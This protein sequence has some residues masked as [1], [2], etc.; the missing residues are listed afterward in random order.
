MTQTKTTKNHYVVFLS[1][2]TFVSES[3]EKEVTKWHPPLAVGK[4]E[5]IVERYGAK[6]YAFYFV[7]YLVHPP[8]D[9]G[10]GG[11][12]EVQRKEIARS[13]LYHLGGNVLSYTDVASRNDPKDSIMLSNMR[14]ND[15]PYVIENTNSYKHC[16]TFGESDV[17]VDARGHITERGD[18]PERMVYRK[19]FR[20]EHS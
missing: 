15:S 1:P 9:D 4:A 19:R 5:R 17:V 8:I 16:S 10:A 2:G 12:L 14:G 13:G 20:K 6:P 3:T 7:T 18:S 11:T